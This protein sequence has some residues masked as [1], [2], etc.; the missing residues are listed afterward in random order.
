VEAIMR[1]TLRRAQM[2]PYFAGSSGV[3]VGTRA[4]DEP[5]LAREDWQACHEVRLMPPADVKA[6]RQAW[7]DRREPMPRRICER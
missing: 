1:K 4:C 2:I 7:E 5:L 3:L 6:L